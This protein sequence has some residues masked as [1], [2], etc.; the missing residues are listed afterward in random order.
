VPQQRL[1]SALGDEA[2]IGRVIGGKYSV[3]AILGRGGMGIVLKA[4]HLRLDEPVAIK[5][6]HASLASDTVM[7]TRML[8]EARAVLR[9]H[10]DHIVRVMDV[11]TLEDGV[12]YLVLE[13]LEGIDLA[14]L[15]R[16]RGAAL[17]W[18]E[19]IAIVDQACRALEEAH[20]FGIVHRDLKP[21]NLF[22]VQRPDGR[23]IVKL[24]DFGISK[25]STS[26]EASITAKGE[27]LGSPRYMAPEQIRSDRP[28]DG[29][30]DIW[31]VG[32][33]LYELLTGDS[34]FAGDNYARAYTRV[35][36]DTPV[37]VATLRPDLPAALS[38][39]VGRCLEK[40]PD[41]RYPD[42]AALRDA[43]VPFVVAEGRAGWP[44]S[45]PDG[46][47]RAFSSAPPPARSGPLSGAPPAA[48][49]LPPEPSGSALAA[50]LSP[51][52]RPRAAGG[53]RRSGVLG[54]AALVVVSAGAAVAL[55]LLVLAQRDQSPPSPAKLATAPAPAASDATSA[56]A[57]PLVTAAATAETPPPAATAEP[58]STAEPAAEATPSADP[59]AA[60]ATSKP[61]RRRTWPLAGASRATAASPSKQP[62]AKPD[63]FGE[64]RQ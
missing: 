54:W 47:G 41:Q 48:T 30:A 20:S 26:Q 44:V 53:G 33:V 60:A 50:D 7:A 58:T 62:P 19:A 39:I 46:A 17:G 31:A 49:P 37:P 61:V 64:R 22:I 52:Q 8:R 12:P 40:D 18:E 14:S 2:W 16:R 9:L 63:P 59:T 1:A 25:L 15:V 56:S 11:D 45:L 57:A 55:M 29:R 32:V 3:E 13:Y 24:L 35:L 34:P 36:E 6:M 10:S 28:L 42:A 51:A 23:R 38:D 27:L 5:V 21:A 43:L 4:R